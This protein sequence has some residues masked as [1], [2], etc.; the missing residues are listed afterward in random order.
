MKLN[1]SYRSWFDV[2]NGMDMID[3]ESDI[4][5]DIT[6]VNTTALSSKSVTPKKNRKNKSHTTSNTFNPTPAT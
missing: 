6:L 5:L 1:S 3:L 2:I 4:T